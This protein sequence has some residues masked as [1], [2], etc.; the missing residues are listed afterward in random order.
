MA[1]RIM[2]WLLALIVLL[3]ALPVISVL[4]ASAIADVQNCPLDE[5]SAHACLLFG[6][7][8]SE[9][10]YTMFVAGWFGLITIPTALVALII[11]GVVWVA[12]FARRRTA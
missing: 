6:R 7:D 5:G 4:A 2:L 10:L 11:W 9:T 1:R 8:I 3:G 12:F